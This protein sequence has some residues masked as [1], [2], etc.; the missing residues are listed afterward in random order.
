MKPVTRIYTRAE[1]RELEEIQETI[2]H[3]ENMTEDEELREFLEAAKAHDAMF[4]RPRGA[5]ASAAVPVKKRAG[6]TVIQMKF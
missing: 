1:G 4:G 5:R 6:A 2:R 3:H